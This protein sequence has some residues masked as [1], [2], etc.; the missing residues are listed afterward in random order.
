[1]GKGLLQQN[2]ANFLGPLHE[3]TV[4][5]SRFSIR[6]RI[7]FFLGSKNN[8]RLN[9]DRNLVFQTSATEI[10]L[11]RVKSSLTLVV[12]RPARLLPESVFHRRVL[13]VIRNEHIQVPDRLS[14]SC[15][16]HVLSFSYSF[17]YLR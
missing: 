2:I 14:F 4:Q 5:F 16:L 1:M 10:F 11:M 7:L 8:G 13:L 6:G 17:V 15:A 9:S 12:L 3:A